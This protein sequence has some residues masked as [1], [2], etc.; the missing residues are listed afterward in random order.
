MYILFDQKW[1]GFLDKKYLLLKW[2]IWIWAAEVKKMLH[3]QLEK[4][5]S[6]LIPPTPDDI[7]NFSLL[8]NEL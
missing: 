6:D 2:L 4:Y 5:T 1:N 3:L 7:V 8:S